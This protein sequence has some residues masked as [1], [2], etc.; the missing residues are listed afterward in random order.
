MARLFPYY[1][2]GAGLTGTASGFSSD[3]NAVTFGLRNGVPTVAPQEPIR[4]YG[5][6]VQLGLPLSRWFNADP[7][8]RNAGWQAYFEYGLDAVNAHDFYLAKDIGATGSGPIKSTIKATTLFYKMNP[9]VQFGFEES[10]YESYGVP[11]SSGAD[12]GVCNGT[13]VAGK[14]SC[15]ATD[16]R[17]EFGPVFTF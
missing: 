15:S 12:K 7:K 10:K 9:W 17:S 6:F 11:A 3:Y 16:R 5:G 14:P 4:G 13:L 8:G 2:Q 1:S